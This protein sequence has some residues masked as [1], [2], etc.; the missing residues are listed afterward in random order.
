MKDLICIEVVSAVVIHR[1]RILLTQRPPGKA[2][3]LVWETPGGK[4]D[5]NES[6]HQALQRELREELGVETCDI[7]E[8]ALWCGGIRSGDTEYFVLLY[9]AT[10]IGPPRPLEGQGIGWFTSTELQCL[11]LAPAN[12][13]ACARLVNAMDRSTERI[14]ALQ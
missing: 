7:P 3:P 6:H 14:G 4:V 11:E 1:G 2:Y 8:H 12:R 13:I 5:G 9:P 10:V